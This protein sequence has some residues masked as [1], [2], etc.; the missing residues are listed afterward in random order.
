[1][2]WRKKKPTNPTVKSPI[3]MKVAGGIVTAALV[4]AALF[5]GLTNDIGA[6]ATSAFEG[7]V[8]MNY[9]DSIGVETWCTGETQVGYKPDGSYDQAYCKALF[10]QS[11][12]GYNARLYGCYSE[13][14]K[15]IVT[16]Q[17]HAAFV[18]MYYNTGRKCNSGMIRNINKGRAKEACDSIL[19]YKYAGGNDCSVPGNKI[20]SG[21]WKRR[22]QMHELCLEGILKE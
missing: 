13:E 16:P 8:L 5:I 11:Y 19:Q 7:T 10:F 21:V 17:I 14:A 4:P 1:M 18:D 6:P 9:Y 12:S 20:C 22:L 3:K 15:T 2:F